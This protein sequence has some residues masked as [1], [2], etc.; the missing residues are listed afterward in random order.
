[1][2]NGKYYIFGKLPCYK[3]S[4]RY[5]GKRSGGVVVCEIQEQGKQSQQLVLSLHT[6][7]TNTHI[8]SMSVLHDY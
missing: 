8:L 3:A 4:K 6:I 1:M 7:Y 5:S 2:I